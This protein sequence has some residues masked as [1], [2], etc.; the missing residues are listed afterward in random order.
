[1]PD[2]SDEIRKGEGQAARGQSE[3]LPGNLT[4]KEFGKVYVPGPGRP[5]TRG[6]HDLGG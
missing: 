1:M 3:L 4:A 5:A 6:V 2:S